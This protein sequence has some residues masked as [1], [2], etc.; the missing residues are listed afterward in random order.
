MGGALRLAALTGCRTHERCTGPQV[1]RM[2]QTRLHV[3]GAA[4]RVSLVNS[5]MASLLVGVYARIE[6]TDGAGM[7]L[8]DIHTRQL[9]KDATG[10]AAAW[11]PWRER[12]RTAAGSGCGTAAVERKGARDGRERLRHGGHGEEGRARRPGAP[13]ARRPWRGRARA[14]AK[15]CCGTAAVERKGSRGGRCAKPR[16]AEMRAATRSETGAARRP[17][18]GAGAARRPEQRPASRSKNQ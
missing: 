14:A 9:C 5:F 3:Y 1:R 7:N 16:P 8:M 4:E 6:E 15:S 18:S 13:A 12:A 10:T 2:H 11:R 17:A